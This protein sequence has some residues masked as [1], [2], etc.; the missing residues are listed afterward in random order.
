MNG[1]WLIALVIAA[2]AVSAGEGQAGEVYTGHAIAMHGAPKYGADFAHFDYVNPDAPKGGMVRLAANGSFDSFN[3]YIIKGL[4]AAGVELLFETLMESSADEA[5]TEYGLIAGKI[6]VAADRSWVTFTLREEARWHDGSAITVADV[7]F[8]FETLK[9]EGAPLY[10]YYYADVASV[11]DLGDRQD[12]RGEPQKAS[13]PSAGPVLRGMQ[14]SEERG[15]GGKCPG[16]CGIGAR[17]PHG[18]RRQGIKSGRSLLVSR[19]A[20]AVGAQGVDDQQD[21]IGP[22]LPLGLATH[23]AEHGGARQRENREGRCPR[24]H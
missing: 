5:F 19:V 11:E 7:I 16:R 24:H 13:D 20:Q 17:E 10:R 1:R 14:R 21:E 8:S 3:P 6:E 18:L 22:R 15:Q 2:L 9:A 12:L 4:A 23:G